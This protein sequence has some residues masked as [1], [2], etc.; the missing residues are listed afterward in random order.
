MAEDRTPRTEPNAHTGVCI[1]ILH[2]AS[3]ILHP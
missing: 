2:H 3:C 1:L